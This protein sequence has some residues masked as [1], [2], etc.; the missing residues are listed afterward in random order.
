MTAMRDIPLFWGDFDQK[1]TR[2]AG[3]KA[4]LVFE[5]VVVLSVAASSSVREDVEQMARVASK[6]FPVA[7]ISKLLDEPRFFRG[8]TYFG[9]AGKLL[10]QIVSNY[11]DMRWWMAKDGL[12][13]D[14]VPPDAGQLSEFDRQAGRMVLEGTRDGK[15][16]DRVFRE[17]AAEL[18][19]VGFA[20][21]ES[22][23][24]AQRKEIVAF[25]QKRAKSAIKSF[26]AAA[27]DRRFSRLVRR[28][29]YVARERY[30]KAYKLVP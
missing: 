6:P 20:F 11:P 19:A 2:E 8:R 5:S 24:P 13:I 10:G 29:L 18:D 15:L 25:N 17:I 26:S 16:S 27:S 30:R 21:L 23:Q 28:R 4:D 3:G 12:V 14:V 1:R 22:L 7:F 9:F